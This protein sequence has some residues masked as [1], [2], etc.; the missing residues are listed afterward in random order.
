MLR[1]GGHI[2]ED[3]SVATLEIK[4]LALQ[5]VLSQTLR[6]TVTYAG[7]PNAGTPAVFIAKF[8]NPD[9]GFA[10]FRLVCGS[11]GFGAFGT[12]Y[13]AYDCMFFE[14]HGVRQPKSYFSSYDPVRET[15]CFVLEDMNLAGY[16][17]GDQLSGGPGEGLPP[18]MEVF[19]ETTVINAKFCAKYF[20]NVYGEYDGKPLLGSEMAGNCSQPFV[21]LVYPLM[22]QAILP[23][24]PAVMEAGGVMPTS[25]PFWKGIE[26]FV[27]NQIGVYNAMSS[28]KEKDGL[29]DCTVQHGDVRSENVFFPKSLKGPPALIDFQLMRKCPVGYDALYFANLSTPVEWR[30]ANDLEMLNVFYD[31]LMDNAV[32]A[33]REELTWEAFCLHIQVAVCYLFVAFLFLTP[34]LAAS[35]KAGDEGDPRK[36]EMTVKMCLRFKAMIED[37]GCDQVGDGTPL[38]EIVKRNKLDPVPKRADW[39]KDALYLIPEKYRN[40]RDP[41]HYQRYLE[42]KEAS[43]AGVEKEIEELQKSRDELLQEEDD[44][45][46]GVVQDGS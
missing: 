7:T 11:A 18:H 17:C 38:D 5:G 25:D 14:N 2:P 8:L 31:V 34:S 20:N 41:A 21:Q 3:C 26:N 44:D 46:E 24:S 6:F 42:Q 15:F 40:G 10:F 12:E 13:W 39:V 28:F 16:Q 23:T 32:G 19:M 33:D 4:P 22:M 30:R 37:W 43:K 9:P 1:G 35:V 36:M 45:E 27:A 29:Y